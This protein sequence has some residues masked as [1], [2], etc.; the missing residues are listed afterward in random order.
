MRDSQLLM[1]VSS[2]YQLAGPAT[3]SAGQSVKVSVSPSLPRGHAPHSG[4]PVQSFT[5]FFFF[6]NLTKLNLGVHLQFKNSGDV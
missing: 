3:P 6:C 2:G 5:A 1:V 4:S